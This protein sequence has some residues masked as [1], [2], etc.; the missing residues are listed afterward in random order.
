[1]VTCRCSEKRPGAEFMTESAHLV[2]VSRG[3]F[4]LYRLAKAFYVPSS[5]GFH[6]CRSSGVS[7][8]AKRLSTHSNRHVSRVVYIHI[9]AHKHTQAHTER[10]TQT[11]H[12]HT[13][14]F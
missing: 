1:M 2:G 12:T 10:D 6:W 7:W 13:H 9:N 4:Y 5:V 14:I 3:S 8:C 11:R